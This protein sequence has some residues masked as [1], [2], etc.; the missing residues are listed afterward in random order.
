M[1][2]CFLLEATFGGHSSL[3]G[4]P[5]VRHVSP[6]HGCAY[7]EIVSDTTS[8]KAMGQ[9]ILFKDFKKGGV[10]S[11]NVGYKVKGVRD[12]VS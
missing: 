10:S 11:V 7:V 5:T 8:V 3:L 12:R 9:T 4:S 2:P 6:S 1:V